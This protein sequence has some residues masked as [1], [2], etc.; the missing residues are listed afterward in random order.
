MLTHN[1]G[2]EAHLVPDKMAP[3]LPSDDSGYLV[4]LNVFH[5]LHCMDN[6]RKGLYY[7]LEPQWNT[8]HNP[9]VLYDSPEAALEDR[10]GDHL[11]IM[12]LDH[13]IDSLR[14]SLQCSADIVPNVFQ[15]SPEHGD[16]RARSTVVHECRNFDKVR[17]C[18]DI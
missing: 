3:E 2:Q 16:V 17:A 5:D 8:T 14:Q 6:I 15:Y 11:S 10:G 4:V 13:C 12:H 18:P 9:Y 1:T 7:F